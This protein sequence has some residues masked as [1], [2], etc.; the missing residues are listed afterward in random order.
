MSWRTRCGRSVCWVRGLHLLDVIDVG[1][2]EL[3]L[4]T[5][6]LERQSPVQSEDVLRQA[7]DSVRAVLERL[8]AA[9][10]QIDLV[11]LL[12]ERFD[13][14]FVEEMRLFYLFPIG[15]M[16][17]CDVEQ[18]VVEVLFDGVGVGHLCF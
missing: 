11:G 12:D 15:I 4:M 18:E 2:L 17:V 14:V 5:D 10:P 16:E 6:D 7:S 1:E 9:E 8:Y 13:V 3:I